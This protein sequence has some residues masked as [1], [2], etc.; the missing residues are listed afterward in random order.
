M[1]PFPYYGISEAKLS[2]IQRGWFS[3]NCVDLVEFVGFDIHTMTCLF[4]VESDQDVALLKLKFDAFS[5]ED[6]SPA[7]SVFIPFNRIAAPGF[8]HVSQDNAAMRPA[9]YDWFTK[10]YY[11]PKWVTKD[12]GVIITVRDIYEAHGIQKFDWT[13]I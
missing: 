13:Q 8:T 5:L 2:N 9:V 10:S 3:E 1:T 12:N 11:N 6:K 4:Y 7:I